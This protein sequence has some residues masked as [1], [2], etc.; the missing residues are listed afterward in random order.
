MKIDEAIAWF[1]EIAQQRVSRKGSSSYGDYYDHQEAVQWLTTAEA[2]IKNVFPPGH[3]IVKKW[4]AVFASERHVG[5]WS[6]DSVVNGARAIFESA[7]SQLKGGRIATL[8]DTI[9]AESVG[10][11]L[12]QAEALVDAKYLAAATVTAGGALESF[13]KHLCERN[14]LAWAGAGSISTY[15]RALAQARNAGKEIISGTYG[16]LI[17]AWGGLRNTAAHTPGQFTQGENEVRAM[18]VGIREFVARHT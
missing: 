11:L 9:R 13:L 8:V 14:A 16:K 17:T 18:I 15:E 12:D 2:A 3:A 7:R 5:R 6:E 10:E 1:D 4:E